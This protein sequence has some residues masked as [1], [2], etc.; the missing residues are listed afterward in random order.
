M[1]MIISMLQAGPRQI[2]PIIRDVTSS[3]AIV[4]ILI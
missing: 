4:R 3:L 2:S 1:T